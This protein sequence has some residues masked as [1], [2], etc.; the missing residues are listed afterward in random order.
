[1]NVFHGLIRRVERLQK[2]DKLAQPVTAAVARVVRPRAVRNL[3]SGTTL[4]HP[5]HPMLTDLPIGAWTMAG[6]FDTL[7]RHPAGR[8]LTPATDLLV[9]AGIV[10]ALPTAVTGLNDWSDTYGPETRVGLVHAAAN[11]TALGLYTASLIARLRNRRGPG[12]A[13]GW[14][15]LVTLV[16][17]GYLGGH[18]S[19]VLGVNVNHTAWQQGP[20][21][22]TPVL[23]AAELSAG[24]TRKVDA[25]G[26]PV[27]L[28]HTGDHIRALDNVCSHAG[29][30]L[31]EGSITDGCVTCPWHGSTFHLADGTVHRGPASTPQPAYH[32]RVRDGNIEIRTQG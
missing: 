27:M 17:G 16:A 19:Y 1:M 11:T 32:T 30:P 14:A 5:A 9:A 22:W 8:A 7:D 28:H 13:L 3:L 4:G 26:T 15:G 21:E 24:Q 25:A 29:G 23:A 18:L 31:H 6:A 10:T 12:K 20:T 2:L